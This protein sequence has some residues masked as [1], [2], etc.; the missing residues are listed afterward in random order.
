MHFLFRLGPLLLVLHSDG[1]GGVVVVV[2]V[3]VVIGR[4]EGVVIGHLHN[5]DANICPVHGFPP[6]LA[7]FATLLPKSFRQPPLADS[8]GRHPPQDW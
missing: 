6:F 8:E 2:V 3:V 7:G 5:L 1:G 4:G